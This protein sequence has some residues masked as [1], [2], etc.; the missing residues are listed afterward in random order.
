METV[1]RDRKMFKQMILLYGY[2]VSY[3]YFHKAEDVISWRFFLSGRINTKSKVLT[4]KLKESIKYYLS[5][6]SS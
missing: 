4:R 3:K 6:D 5:V 2:Y 1:S